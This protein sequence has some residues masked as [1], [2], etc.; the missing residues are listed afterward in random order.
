MPHTVFAALPG[1]ISLTDAAG[2]LLFVGGITF[3]AVADKQKST[4]MA[5]KKEKRHSEEFLTRGLWGKSRHPNYFGEV[6]LWTGIATVAGGVLASRA[7]VGAMGL[8]GGG[9]VGTA[10]ALGMAGVSPGFVSLLLFKVSLPF[11]SLFRNTLDNWRRGQN[12]D[13]S[14]TYRSRGFL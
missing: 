4:W 6:T 11:F 5:E 1:L 13:V 2:V 7:G 14:V 3:E 8:G 9:L 12:A 10:V